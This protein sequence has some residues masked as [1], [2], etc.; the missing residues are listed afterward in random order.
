MDAVSTSPRTCGA[1]GLCCKLMGV[2]ELG[3]APRKW[4]GHF[5]RAS[6]CDIYSQR[7]SACGAFNCVW[8]LAANLDE[9]WRPDRAGFLMHSE[10]GGR[11]LVVEADP[12]LP[13]AWKRSPYLETLRR[14]A[15][16]G[17]RRGVEVLIFV[18]DRGVR[19]GADGAETPVSRVSA[20]S[21]PARV[22]GP[23]SR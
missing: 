3:K 17:E 1:C 15:A 12:A 2:A 19:L 4:C 8:L 14:W 18:G 7:P 10:D 23:A 22:A 21:A 9:T 6:G 20:P 5:R 16:D 13:Q 11:R